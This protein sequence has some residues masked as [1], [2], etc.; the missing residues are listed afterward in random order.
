[1]SAT[2]HVVHVVQNLAIGGLERVVLDLVTHV[3]RSRYRC[4]IVCLGAGGDLGEQA[5]AAGVPVRALDKGPGFRVGALARLARIL[6]REHAALVHCHNT[7]P[8]VYGA[9]AG[10]MAGAAGVVYTAHG[11]KTSGERKP[12]LLQRLGLVDHFVTVSEDA[13]RIAVE[14]AGAPAERVA[15]V[16]NG[17]D[18]AAFADRAD[19][20]GRRAARAA[21]G[22]P[23]DGFVFGIVARLS[24]AKDHARLFAAFAALAR[25]D[26]RVRLVVVGD[27]ERRADLEALVG[28]LDMGDHIRMLGSRR[29]VAD[30]LATFDCFVLSSYTEG[31]AVR[32]GG[33]AEVV[34]DGETGV[35]VPPRDTDG[36]RDAME[37]MATHP[38]E[39]GAL[40]ARGRARVAER[41]SVE[42]MARSYEAVYARLLARGHPRAR[43]GAGAVC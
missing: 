20:A 28:E 31:L 4:S 23:A 21:M 8:L 36:L 5:V 35:I 19:A 27:G 12:V 16:W 33:N 26:A 18:V 15:T 34:V 29:D 11:M 42:A 2:A 37:W 22:V 40:G 13:R 41:F 43:A 10:R 32:V 30:L 3:D 1:V 9:L 25:R 17:V 24:A 6:R 14:R 39:A 38:A 7:A